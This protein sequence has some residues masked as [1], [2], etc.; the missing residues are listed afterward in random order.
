MVRL[1]KCPN[2]GVTVV[3]KSIGQCSACQNENILDSIGLGNDYNNE[4][5]VLTS[6]KAIK[7]K[8]SN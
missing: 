6:S 7:S 1:V 8:G 3:P 4:A 2:C 5:S